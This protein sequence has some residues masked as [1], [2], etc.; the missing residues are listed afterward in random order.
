[1][2]KDCEKINLT[3]TPRVYSILK[4]A[5]GKELKKLLIDLQM[6]R[7]GTQQNWEKVRHKYVERYQELRDFYGDDYQHLP[8]CKELIDWKKPDNPLYN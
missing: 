2:V 5:L 7:R 1:M 3:V 4:R 8:K 6:V